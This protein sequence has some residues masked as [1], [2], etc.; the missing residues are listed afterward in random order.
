MNINATLFGQM[1]TFIVFVVLTMK[2]V[3]PP[4]SKALKERQERIAQG[5]ANSDRAAHELTLAQ[6][7]ATEILRDTKTE[8]AR[9]V[10][11][12]M[13]RGQH[14]VEEAKE[15]AR[16]EG[17]R[18]IARA[19]EQIIID[20]ENA[21]AALRQEIAHIALLGAQ[22]I[23]QKQLDSTSNNEMIDKLIAEVGSE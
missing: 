4:I 22:R 8:A 2:Y 12:A 9:L 23:V 13:K 14:F 20:T 16:K 7:K 6:Q 15:Q 10:E 21:K 5:L 17:E 19:H 1:I 11:E 3:W 18:I